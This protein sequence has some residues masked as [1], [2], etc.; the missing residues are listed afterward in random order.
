M[1]NDATV[2]GSTAGPPSAPDRRFLFATCFIALIATSFAFI[3]R[4]I[5]VD[6]WATQFG[7]SETQKGE[8]FGAG[9][10][11]FAIS[12]IVFS[13]IID[14]V[15]YRPAMFFALFCHISSV[16]VTVL[17]DGYWGLY[18]GNF[19]AALGNGTVEAVINPVIAA[20]YWKHKTKWLNILHAGWP[21]G[22]ALGG[23]LTISLGGTG[24][25]GGMFETAPSW[26]WKVGLLLIPAAIYGVMLLKARFPVSEREAAGVSY[27]AMLAEFGGVGMFIAAWLIFTELGRVWGWPAWLSWG[28]I[29]ATVVTYSAYARSVGRPMFVFLLLVMILLA[30]TEIGTD[31]WIASLMGPVMEDQFKISGGWVLVYTATI[32]MTLRLFCGP[33]VKKLNPLG[34]LIVS[35]LFAAAGLA[36][37]SQAAGVVIIIAATVYGIGQTFFWP[38]TLGLVAERFPKGGA[39][40][41][42]AI[43]GVGMLGVGILGFPLLGN[44]QDKHTAAVLETQQPEIAESVFAD[45][46]VDSVLGRYRK[47]DGSRV[48]E[49]SGAQQELVTGVQNEAKQEALFQVAVL[50]LI[51]AVCYAGLLIWFKQQGGYKPVLLG[52]E[53]EG[54]NV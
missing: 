30:T 42:N 51:M 28:L 34:M 38:T 33:I 17:A 53:G 35:C 2:S 40:T 5:I 16:I 9:I 20:M 19:I 52:H 44:I 39:L 14:K 50:P 37:L 29:G 48:A 6:D 27:R 43:A 3:I 47:L 12:I 21:G 49:L 10:W 11:P 1:L 18:W 13:L 26:H 8:L 31:G 7:L 32:M 22:L 24:V 54:G 25:I 23:V 15:G 41:L 36:F 45:K 4:A 46:P